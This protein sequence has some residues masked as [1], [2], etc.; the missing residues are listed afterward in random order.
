MTGKLLLQ[1][2]WQDWNCREWQIVEIFFYALKVEY[3]L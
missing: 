1:Q 2:F 3:D